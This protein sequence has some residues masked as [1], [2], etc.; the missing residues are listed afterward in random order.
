MY[1]STYLKL[2]KKAKLIYGIIKKDSWAGQGCS[3]LKWV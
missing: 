2:K 1:D 3:I